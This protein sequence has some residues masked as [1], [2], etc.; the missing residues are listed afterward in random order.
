[1]KITNDLNTK[2]VDDLTVLDVAIRNCQKIPAR[3]Q[4]HKKRAVEVKKFR[5]SPL[6]TATA[7]TQ[8]Q[9]KNRHGFNH[10]EGYLDYLGERFPKVVK[11]RAVKRTLQKFWVTHPS[12]F[13]HKGDVR[14][15]SHQD[16]VYRVRTQ[17]AF[18]LVEHL[19][20]ETG[21]S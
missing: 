9:A 7:P 2:L 1:M 13:A 6:K 18:P 10:I 5:T 11:K 17:S 19:S 16:E 3:L 15:D 21:Y 20:A 14:V 12:S 4:V 8:A